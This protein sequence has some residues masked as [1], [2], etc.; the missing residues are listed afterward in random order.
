VVASVVWGTA[1]TVPA[2]AHAQGELNFQTSNQSPTDKSKITIKEVSVT[3]RRDV[4]GFSSGG[5]RGV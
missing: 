5:A 2:R 1:E 4:A 3:N